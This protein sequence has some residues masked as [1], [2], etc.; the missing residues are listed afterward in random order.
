MFRREHRV[1]VVLAQFFPAYRASLFLRGQH[2]S[3]GRKRGRR[4]P[5][6]AATTTSS[7]HS[8]TI[9]NDPRRIK[10]R[11][12]GVGGYGRAARNDARLRREICSVQDP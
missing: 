3:A 4:G 1:R 2:L 12:F 8:P 5:R 7:I 9:R 6:G 11:A 10:R